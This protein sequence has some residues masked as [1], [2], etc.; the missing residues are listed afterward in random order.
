[1]EGL[2]GVLPLGEV[3]SRAWR[4]TKSRRRP[5]DVKPRSISPCTR[6]APAY[7][8]EEQC[9]IFVR[10]GK[11][12][13]LRLGARARKAADR[14]AM[15]LQ[16]GKGLVLPLL[17]RKGADV[18]LECRST[19]SSRGCCRA[20]RHQSLG[21][22]VGALLVREL[23]RRSPPPAPD[24]VSDRRRMAK[25]VKRD[26]RDEW[27]TSPAA[28]ASTPK[29]SSRVAEQGGS[30]TSCRCCS[31]PD[32]ATPPAPETLGQPAG[33]PS[34]SFR[35][36][37]SCPLDDLRCCVLSSLRPDLIASTLVIGLS[38]RLRRLL[39]GPRFG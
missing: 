27:F 16:P 24:R 30:A 34:A 9:R 22:N 31:S 29:G 5:P 36:L 35:V 10:A 25:A 7:Y 8:V 19:R 39:G 15:L 13:L 3:G 21:R 1:M 18:G 26:G 12:L 14:T 17:P 33:A 20:R 23:R 2:S 38:Q 4:S 6:N 32:T 11:L 37:V 28:R